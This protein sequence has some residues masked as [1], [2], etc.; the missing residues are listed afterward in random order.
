MPVEEAIR[1]MSEA[2][3]PFPEEPRLDPIHELT[4]TIRAR[5]AGTG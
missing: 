4:F 3:G 5:R 2:Y 1:L